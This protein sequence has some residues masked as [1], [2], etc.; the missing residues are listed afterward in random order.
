MPLEVSFAFRFHGTK[1]TL[2][3]GL[4]ATFLPHVR[5]KIFLHTVRS[6]TCSALVRF[7]IWLLENM[8]HQHVTTYCWRYH[9]VSASSRTFQW[10]SCTKF[11]SPIGNHPNFIR[12]CNKTS[13]HL[14][15]QSRDQNNEELK[16]SSLWSKLVSWLI[17]R[18]FNYAVSATEVIQHRKSLEAH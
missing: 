14:P 2:Q 11:W 1:W 17:Y 5:Q 3:M 6:S 12:P 8:I 13:E 9:C 15:Y 7:S 16:V 10:A 18:F 4:P